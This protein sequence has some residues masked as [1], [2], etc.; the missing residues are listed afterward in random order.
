MDQAGTL[1]AG[2]ALLEQSALG[3]QAWARERETAE[4]LVAAARARGELANLLEPNLA[5]DVGPAIARQ[6]GRF[7]LTGEL[8]RVRERDGILFV[9]DTFAHK[10][11]EAELGFRERLPLFIRWALCRLAPENA[12]RRVRLAALVNKGG[13]TPWQSAIA[14]WDEKFLQASAAERDEQRAQLETRLAFVID[15]ATRPATDPWP[16]FPRT[17]WALANGKEDAGDVWRRELDYA[18][19]YARLLGRGL[20]PDENEDWRLALADAATALLNAIRLGDAE[21]AA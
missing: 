9:C 15:A 18:P 12:K 4:A 8:D 21:E 1:R 3:A 10:G 19:G 2:Q 17:S 5:P 7:S 13:K 11:S 20:A 16:Y 6:V 14:D